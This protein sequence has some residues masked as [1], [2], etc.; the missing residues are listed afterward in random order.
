MK[1]IATTNVGGMVIGKVYDV[2]A[3]DALTLTSVNRA[4]YLDDSLNTKTEKVK[5]EVIDN[6]ELEPIKNEGL[7]VETLESEKIIT[8]KRK[9]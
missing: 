3:E 6:Q 9:K 7:V 8:K 1:I 5:I 4:K 2:S